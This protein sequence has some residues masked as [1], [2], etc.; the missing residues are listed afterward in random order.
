MGVAKLAILKKDI[1]L[2]FPTDYDIQVAFVEALFRMML[3]KCR[4]EM[5]HS[6]F[7][8]QYVTKVFREIKDE[9]FET[10]RVFVIHIRNKVMGKGR[11]K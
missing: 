11:K 8:D 2:F 1:F 9:D 5:V 4:D 10:V 3:R 6:W 7:E